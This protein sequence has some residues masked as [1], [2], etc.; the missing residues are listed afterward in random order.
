[1]SHETCWFLPVRQTRSQ[2]KLGLCCLLHLSGWRKR[3]L[4]IC[5]IDLQITYDA[6]KVL[7]WL[8]L[9]C[10][11]L[12]VSLTSDS[13]CRN[14]SQ[15]DSSGP[16]NTGPGSPRCCCLHHRPH[17]CCWHAG[18][19]SRCYGGLSASY[20]WGQ[21][22]T[23]FPRRR[24]ESA[25]AGAGE[26]AQGHSRGLESILHFNTTVESWCCKLEASVHLSVRL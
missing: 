17:G 1:M 13:V 18:L 7:S 26:M 19:S 20:S 3:L 9:L 10:V 21:A 14:S 23:Y 4:C 6:S 15:R 11:T 22:G 25:E 12:I 2:T 16:E 8:E 5:D 24:R